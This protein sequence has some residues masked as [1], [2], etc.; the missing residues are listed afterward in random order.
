MSR[1]K[2]KPSS[3]QDVARRMQQRRMADFE[4]LGL[5][6]DVATLPTSNDVEVRPPAKNNQPSQ[7]RRVAARMDAFA[8]LE[9]GMPVASYVAAR[10]LQADIT[11]RKGEQDRGRNFDR[12][13]CDKPTDRTD[14]MI[15][16]AKRIE[17]VFARLG[18]H[19]QWLLTELASPS[20]VMRLNHTTWR[21][22]VQYITGEEDAMAQAGAVRHACKELA[23]VYAEM[24]RAPRRAMA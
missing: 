2:P 20:D 24:D 23:L 10:R 21:A 1:R 22:V 4:A 18:G 13:D 3:P 15:A 19:T 9:A 7:R 11:I 5:A 6:S 17:A 14:A 16:A 12:V 8:A